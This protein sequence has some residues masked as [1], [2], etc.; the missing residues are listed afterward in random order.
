ML[1]PDARA[2]GADPAYAFSPRAPG[3]AAAV[4]ADLGQHPGTGN[5]GEP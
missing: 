2:T 1:R 4:V 5:I 3:G